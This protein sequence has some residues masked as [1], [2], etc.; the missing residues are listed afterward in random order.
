MSHKTYKI[1][2]FAVVFLIVVGTVALAAA[3]VGDALRTERVP[4]PRLETQFIKI[5]S[6]RPGQLV[7]SPLVVTGEAR[8]WYFEGSFPIEIKDDDGQVLA[9]GQAIAQTDW[10]VD[11]FVPFIAKLEFA[12]PK[13]LTG[14]L[15]LKKDN[16]SALPANDD[17]V[18][19]PVQ[20]DLAK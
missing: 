18:S 17:S 11:R 12:A 3:A 4:V 15:V 7:R 19:L 1:L 2:I 20:F 5:E 8:G 13:A 6:P 16:P 9:S 14:T 10:M